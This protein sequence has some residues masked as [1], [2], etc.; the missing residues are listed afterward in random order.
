MLYRVVQGGFPEEVAPQL[1]LKGE[2]HQSYNRDRGEEGEVGVRPGGCAWCGSGECSP[3][4]RRSHCE[5]VCERW[6]KFLVCVRNSKGSCY[7]RT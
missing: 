5:T 3:G 4:R 7:I 6:G 2:I 1:H